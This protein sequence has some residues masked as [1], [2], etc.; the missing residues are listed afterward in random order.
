MFQSSKDILF[1][2]ISFCII[3]LTVFLCWMFYYL[4]RIFKD[5]SKIIEEF[6]MRLQ[7]L[8]DMIKNISDK[9]EKLHGVISLVSTG[10]GNFMNRRGSKKDSSG[11]DEEESLGAKTSRFE[12]AA[13]DVVDRAVEATAEKM[14]KI[15]R[16]IRK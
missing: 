2:V 14:R 9:V 10:F 3:S 7:S 8:T 4:M 15:G 16:R 12:K 5:T 13:K 1:L 11:D 6:R